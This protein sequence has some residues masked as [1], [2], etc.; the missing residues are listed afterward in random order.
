LSD[1]PG[2]T[3]AEA[4]PANVP[5]YLIGQ[6]YERLAHWK[7]RGQVDGYGCLIL[8]RQISA[9]SDIVG[10]CERIR[11]S[12]LA[13]SYRKGVRLAIFFYLF[14]LPWGLVHDFMYWTLPVTLALTY[15]MVGLELVAEAVEEPFGREQDDLPTDEIAQGIQASI[16]EILRGEPENQESPSLVAG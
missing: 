14:T 4:R 15:L 5:V 16:E 13:H 8:D 12:P 1:L 2:F 3:H 11:K 10:G 7:Q 9:F 6:M